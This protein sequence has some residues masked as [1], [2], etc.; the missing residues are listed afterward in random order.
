MVVAIQDREERV[1]HCIHCVGRRETEITASRRVDIHCT[2]R[3]PDLAVHAFR[4]R[5]AECIL[6]KVAPQQAT[7]NHEIH[8]PREAV[9]DIPEEY[10]Q[11]QQV[12]LL[13]RAEGPTRKVPIP[14]GRAAS[15]LQPQQLLDALPDTLVLAAPAGRHAD[16]AMHERHGQGQRGLEVRACPLQGCIHSRGDEDLVLHPERVE[17]GRQELGVAASVRPFAAFALACV[18]GL[19]QPNCVVWCAALH[20]CQPRDRGSGSNGRGHGAQGARARQA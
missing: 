3:H 12:E 8:L 20:G 13:L 15:A 9:I 19:P 6:K 4:P 2:V 16:V 18:E 11:D 17:G 7:A 14:E 1:A 10:R 5:Q